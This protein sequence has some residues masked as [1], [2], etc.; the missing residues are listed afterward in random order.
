LSR[1]VPWA[2]AGGMPSAARGRALVP[3]L[4]AAGLVTACGGGTAAGA[5]PPEAVLGE[6][7]LTGWT[8]DGADVATPSVATATLDVD[9]E[10]LGGR[11]FCNSYSGEYTVDGGRIE[12]SGL[13]GTD[14]GCDPDVMSAESEFLAALGAASRVDVRAGV[15][16][17]AGGQDELRFE[18]VPP[19]PTRELVGTTWEFDSVVDGDSA[20][21]TNTDEPLTLRVSEDGTVTTTTGCRSLT[22]TWQTDGGTVTVTDHGWSGHGCGWTAIE[23]QDEHIV[24]VLTG[25][26]TVTI[27]GDV[28]TLDGAD[29]RG[30]VYRAAG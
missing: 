29:G 27:E 17:L 22:G 7:Q 18:V 10:G 9:A 30:I 24:D 3:L 28:L 15:L 26:F 16:T 25:G 20:S 21:A 2:Q 5:L 11:S 19:E 1:V 4:L 14:M 12:V 13:G 23:Q 6:W 8:R